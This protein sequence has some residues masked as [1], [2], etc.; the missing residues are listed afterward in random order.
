MKSCNWK[1]CIPQIAECPSS[2]KIKRVGSTN[3]KQITAV[4]I[5][6]SELVK[7][8]YYGLVGF[9]LKAWLTK[10]AWRN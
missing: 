7:E 5:K 2:F 8:N 6:Y 9:R 3:V 4:P 10:Y 1:A